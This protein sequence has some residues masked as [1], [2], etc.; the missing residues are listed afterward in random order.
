M[1]TESDVRTVMIL[2]TRWNAMRKRCL[3]PRY[4]EK[5]VYIDK[6][7]R[8]A[9]GF[10]RFV[11]WAVNNGFRPEFVIDRRNNNGPYSPKNC[12]WVTQSRNMRNTMNSIHVVFRG[13]KMHVKDLAE[14]ADCVVQAHI[15]R[16]R[17]K[18]GWSVEEA[19][20]RPVSHGNGWFRG[21]RRHSN[22]QR[23]S[24]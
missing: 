17:I 23:K 4:V 22:E 9:R 15:L 18:G 20:T 2:A 3:R 24:V 10:E 11:V 7:W 1:I 5:G 13:K 6:T 19:A 21:T 8:G 12:W 14:S 16:G